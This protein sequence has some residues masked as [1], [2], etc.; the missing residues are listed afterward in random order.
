MAD[1]RRLYNEQS[2]HGNLKCRSPDTAAITKLR[3]TTAKASIFILFAILT[4]TSNKH[5]KI[6]HQSLTILSENQRGVDAAECKVV[7]HDIFA[8]SLAPFIDDVIEV[9]AV[10]IDLG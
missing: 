6:D 2:E 7:G 1:Q 5:V 9:S 10:R 8:L 3:M 4:L